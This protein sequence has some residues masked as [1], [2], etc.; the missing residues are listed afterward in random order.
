MSKLKT[1]HPEKVLDEINE[2]RRLALQGKLSI[3]GSD[4][5]KE[6]QERANEPAEK[7]LA[8]IKKRKQQRK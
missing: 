5:V 4:Y 2:L 3:P 7:I 1:V 6:R 8:R